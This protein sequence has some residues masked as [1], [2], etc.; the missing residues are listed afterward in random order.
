MLLKNSYE[1][2]FGEIEGEA[3]F[4]YFKKEITDLSKKGVS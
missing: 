4:P 3:Y 1:N 2:K